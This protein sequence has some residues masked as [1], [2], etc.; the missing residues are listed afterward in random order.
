MIIQS[1]IDKL[2]RVGNQI[3][4]KKKIKKKGGD[5]EKSKQTPSS[6]VYIYYT[7]HSPIEYSI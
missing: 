3:C 7:I 4:T 6:I 2:E 1:D 5:S